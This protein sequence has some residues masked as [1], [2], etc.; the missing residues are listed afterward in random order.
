MS[1]PAASHF[2]GTLPMVLEGEDSA[3]SPRGTLDTVSFEVLC[4]P[5]SW[6]SELAD[7]GIVRDDVLPGSFGWHSMWVRDHTIRS[8][9]DST[10]RIGVS[11]VGLLEDEEKRKSTVKAS[12]RRKSISPADPTPSDLRDSTGELVFNYS[13]G[14]IWDPDTRTVSDRHAFPQKISSFDLAP[15]PNFTV[16]DTTDIVTC[17]AAHELTTGDAV[18]MQSTTTLPAPLVAATRYYVIVLDTTTFYLCETPADAFSNNYVDLTDT[19]TGT[20]SITASFQSTTSPSWEVTWVEYAITTRFFTTTR[21]DPSI[22]GSTAVDLPVEIDEP[23]DPFDDGEWEGLNLR[24]NEASGWT[25]DSRDIDELFVGPVLYLGG[26]LGTV[27]TGLWAVTDTIVSKP[28]Y[29]PV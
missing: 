22:A 25:Y 20:H 28:P 1:T 12:L 21:P 13:N 17:A 2:H 8:K 18:T 29:T 23:T 3:D 14:G 5:S 19:G 16:N 6:R 15:N 11:C 9:T 24:L 7:L 4:T 26:D 10:I 27:E